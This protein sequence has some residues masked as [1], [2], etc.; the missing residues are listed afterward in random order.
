VPVKEGGKVIGLIGLGDREGGYDE[1]QQDTVAALATAFGVALQRKRAEAALRDSQLR[2]Q[3]LAAQLIDAQESERKRIALELHDDLGQILMVLKMQ[4][5]RI[6]KQIPPDQ[7]QVQEGMQEMLDLIGEIVAKV[8]RISHALI[9]S[10]LEDLGL[11]VVLQT[12]FA[13]WQKHFDVKVEADIEDVSHLAQK[14]GGI[15]VYRIFQEFLHN[16]AKHAD[17]TAVACSAKKQGDRL[18]FIL[19][20]DGRGFDVE[21][22]GCGGRSGQ[23]LGLASME[24]RV[25]MLGSR[26]RLWSRPGR[27]TRLSFELPM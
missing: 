25:R 12:L 10:E 20:D 3:Q 13:D 4:V 8:R 24:E 5:N 19:A 26:L 2:L 14:S 1:A 9:P 16:V 11:L 27:G 15:Q 17:A 6:R 22:G 7:A 18:V 23:G 21:A